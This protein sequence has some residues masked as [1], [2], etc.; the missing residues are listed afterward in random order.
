MGNENTEY[1]CAACKRIIKSHVVSCK[2]CTGAYFHPGC[3]TKHRSSNAN[4]ENVTCKGPYDIFYADEDEGSRETISTEEPSDVLTVAMA[5]RL[6]DIN[7]SMMEER[8][9]KEY[10]RE[11]QKDEE[12]R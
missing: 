1:K 8:V 9:K 11:Q 12:D 2:Q 3:M 5:K 4:K 7:E 10:R 6:M